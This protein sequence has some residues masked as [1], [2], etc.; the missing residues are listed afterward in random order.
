MSKLF[1]FKLYLYIN[2]YFNTMN[3]LNIYI[4]TTS[5][6]FI[7]HETLF[8]QTSIQ[9][10]AIIETYDLNTLNE[11]AN[12]FNIDFQNNYTFGIN[13]ALQN[14]LPLSGENQ[15]GSFF[16]LKGFDA[17]LNNVVY[18]N[19]H[20]NTSTKSSIQTARVQKLHNGYL[21]GQEITGNNMILGIWDGAIP[22]ADHQNLGI[23]RVIDK[24]LE[25][26]NTPL[27]SSINHATH[28]AGTMIGNG[29]SQIFAKGLAP[30]AILWANTW[31]NDLAEMTLQAS[32]GLLIS[33]H[34]YGLNNRA[35]VN[36]PG[37]F[38]LY[39][40]AAQN[41]DKLTYNADMF[42]PIYSAGNDRG[43]IFYGGNLVLLNS[44]KLGYDLM[45][46]ECVAKNPVVVAA[47]VGITNYTIDHQGTNNVEMSTFS[48]WGPTD[49]F[50]IKPDISAKGVSVYSSTGTGIAN[51]SILS[52][53][54]MAAPAVSAVFS[55]WQQIH[56]SFWPEANNNSGFMKA[57]S[58]KALMAHTA[59]EAGE[60]EG[61]DPKFGWGLI[62][63]ERGGEILKEASQNKTI[64][65]EHTLLNY[66]EIKYYITIDGTQPLTATMAWT[67][68]ES[69]PTQIAE[70]DTS[71]LINDLDM[72]ISFTTNNNTETI[73]Y[74]WVMNKSWLNL[75]ATRG[76]NDADPIEKITYFNPNTGLA[77]AGNYVITINHKG[78]LNSEKQNFS[79]FITGGIIDYQYVL[80]N[81]F[82]EKTEIKLFPNPST[83][84]I[85]V[86]N[87]N[88]D[89]IELYDYLGRKIN[90]NYNKIDDAFLTI[91][92]QNLS[93]GTY[94]ISLFKNK[95]KKTLNFIKN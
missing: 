3:K 94:F 73:I 14:N 76:D 52:G 40:N 75:Y 79:L 77:P 56:N 54:S 33:N 70:S 18:Y 65:K 36:L 43:G 95:I 67:D 27:Q 10:Q 28:V 78:E 83:D 6:F 41:I 20:N 26:N 64:F 50:R 93:K 11:I 45:T 25:Y 32:E 59:S 19:S 37:Y 48:Q 46:N 87:L 82:F 69:E 53:T 15:D 35:Y 49:D 81:A 29:N 13:Y 88:Y 91:N 89:K 71:K 68:K 57:A 47:V 86:T 9:R 21:L 39:T 31:H 4:I 12:L 72:R 23:N 7:S 62:N 80:D 74:P 34:S 16:S 17:Q 8:S 22:L 66:Q 63:A 1:F 44:S 92:I 85:N 51:Y 61:P 42:L 38:G 55:L 30:L 24:D 5:L 60:F 58:V 84:F 2:K 90:I